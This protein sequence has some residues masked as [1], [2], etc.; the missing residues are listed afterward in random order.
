VFLAG[1]SR[2]RRDG[3]DPSTAA[4]VGRVAVLLIAEDDDCKTFGCKWPALVRSVMP[5][6]IPFWKHQDH[7]LVESM[8]DSK[9]FILV[10]ISE[11]RNMLSW[12]EIY[13]KNAPP[14]LR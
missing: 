6:D 9:K 11:D 5:D 10:I 3:S 13:R 1:R 14:R 7:I 2:G 8:T 12:H 4:Y